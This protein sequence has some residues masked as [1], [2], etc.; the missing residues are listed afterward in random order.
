MRISALTRSH[1]AIASISK[2]Q[3]R[4]PASLRQICSAADDTARRSNVSCQAVSLH[5]RIDGVCSFICI[6]F[7][8]F[9][10]VFLIFIAFFSF[11]LVELYNIFRLFTIVHRKKA[12]QICGKIYHTISDAISYFLFRKPCFGSFSETHKKHPKCTA[13]AVLFQVFPIFFQY[14]FFTICFYSAAQTDS[15]PPDRQ[16]KSA[17]TTPSENS[18][19]FSAATVR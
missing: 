17:S 16:R 12:P 15:V 6:I 10:C 7:L 3:S 14:L 4:E 5:S 13:S 19:R 11:L 1:K 2:C 9:L 8:F 18:V